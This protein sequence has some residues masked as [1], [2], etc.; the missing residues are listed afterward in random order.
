MEAAVPE[1]YSAIVMDMGE[2]RGGFRE[3]VARNGISM[4]SG[5]TLLNNLV[6][7]GDV[8]LALTLYQ[9]MP[10]AAKRN[11]APIDWFVPRPRS[12]A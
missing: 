3:L 4:R 2:E 7:A 9:Y 12:P 10:E 5:H 1:W 8:A 6:I 11:G